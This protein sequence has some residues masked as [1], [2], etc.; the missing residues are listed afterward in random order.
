MAFV[1]VCPLCGELLSE[2]QGRSGVFLRC[3]GFPDCRYAERDIVPAPQAASGSFESAAANQT[4]NNPLTTKEVLE[5][6]AGRVSTEETGTTPVVRA[7]SDSEK[8]TTKKTS[9]RVVDS[10]LEHTRT[11]PAS[12]ALRPGSLSGAK[13]PAGAPILEVGRSRRKDSTTPS[14]TVISPGIGGEVWTPEETARYLKISRHKL[15]RMRQTKEGPSYSRF[16]KHIRYEKDEV[17]RWIAR[18][19]E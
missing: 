9:M 16:G 19:R 7:S 1:R 15:M 3:Q 13:D 4:K 11:A 8:R 6:F 12:Q 2:Q 10:D 17:L 18:Q 5:G 14:L